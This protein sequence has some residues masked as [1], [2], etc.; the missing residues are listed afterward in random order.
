MERVSELFNINT[1]IV[2]QVNPHLMPFVVRDNYTHEES[3]L[4]HAL[5]NTSK[6]LLRNTGAYFVN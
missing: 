4:K 1:Y 2:S 3:L 5:F 6:T